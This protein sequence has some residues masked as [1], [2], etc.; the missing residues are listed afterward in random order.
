[1][2]LL[3]I[4]KYPDP[5]LA[6][7]C[8]PVERVDDE[9]RQLI[10][11]MLETMYAAEGVGLAAAQVGVTKRIIVLD[12]AQERDEEGKLKNQQPYA[13]INPVITHK[14]GDI[15]WEEGCLSVPEYVDEVERARKVV[16]AGRL[17]LR[18]QPAAHRGGRPPGGVPADQIHY[19]EGVLFVDRL[20]R[21]KQSLVKK[22]LKKRAAERASGHDEEEASV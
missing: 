11:D 2:A 18:G 10:D 4:L 14:E 8:T 13:I 21:L 1:M 6:R 9:I 20:S 22:K 19:L 16:C 12:C 15:V 17:P 7:K 5:R 3:E